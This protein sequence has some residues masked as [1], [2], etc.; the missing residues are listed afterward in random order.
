MATIVAI[1]PGLAY[2]GLAAVETDGSAHSIIA[3]DVYVTSKSD[4]G[5]PPLL[6]DD[7]VHRARHIRRWMSKCMRTYAPRAV[8]IEDFGFLQQAYS[9]ACLAMA[10]QAC[11]DAID[12]HGEEFEF[13]PVVSAS[14]NVWRTEL[15]GA[16]SQPRQRTVKVSMSKDEKL[17]AKKAD[18][19]FNRKMTLEREKR[20]HVEALRRVSGASA[21]LSLMPVTKSVHTLDALG[22]FC[23][24]VTTTPVKGAIYGRTR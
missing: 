19:E 1:D 17:A 6:R 16:L 21:K 5:P 2:C 4:P 10:Y 22:L 20:A 13:V 12:A 18:R 23:W 7:R 24:G 11:I 14:A 9:T 15:A 3:L 8:V